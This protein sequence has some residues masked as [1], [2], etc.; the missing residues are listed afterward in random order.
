M[1]CSNKKDL[2]EN[3]SKLRQKFIQVHYPNEIIQEQFSRIEKVNRKD[4]ILNLGLQKKG[5]TLKKA[6]HISTFN[7]KNPPYKKWF[8]ELRHILDKD[9]HNKKIAEKI[10]FVTRQSKNLQKALTSA[11]IK[12]ENEV[13]RPIFEQ[14]AGSSKCNRCHACEKFKIPKF[15]EVQIPKGNTKFVKK[16]PAD[17]ATSYIL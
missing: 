4:L 3:L 7:E 15:S 5:K 1:L 13:R 2:E 16:C 12:N 17:Q 6:L 11:K 14:G 9:P 8:K 10:M